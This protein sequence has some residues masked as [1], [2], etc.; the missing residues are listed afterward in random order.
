MK[1][2]TFRYGLMLLAALVLMLAGAVAISAQP[3]S[4]PKAGPSA[5]PQGKESVRGWLRDLK[6]TDEELA[7]ISALVGRDEP[8]LAKARADIRVNQANIARLLLEAEPDR[9]AVAAELDK[10]F[11]AEKTIRMVQIDRQIQVKSIF[12]EKRWKTILLIA[13]EARVAESMGRLKESFSRKG[14]TAK[15]A[16]MWTRTLMLLKNCL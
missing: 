14:L 4:G 6:I 9:A 12:G 2:S 10:S 1:R 7:K 8:A 11:A 16:E 3:M 13:K 15:E 5:G